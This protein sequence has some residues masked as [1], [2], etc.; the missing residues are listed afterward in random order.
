MNWP[1]NVFLLFFLFIIMIITD[2]FYIFCS[3]ENYI[4]NS[5]IWDTCEKPENVVE[6][7]ISLFVTLLVAACLELLLCGFQVLN[8]LFG[9]ICGTCNHKEEVCTVYKNDLI[10]KGQSVIH[11]LHLSCN[12]Y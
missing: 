5:D 8:G 1:L 2:L 12:S 6:F 11:L 7:N 9:C 4:G 3:T 10:S